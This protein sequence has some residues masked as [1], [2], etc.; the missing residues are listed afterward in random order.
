[1]TRKE[2]KQICNKYGLSITSRGVFK[3]IR[4]DHID[5][6][7]TKE[8]EKYPSETDDADWAAMWFIHEKPFHD[9]DGCDHYPEKLLVMSELLNIS[10]TFTRDEMQKMFD[11]YTF[12]GILILHQI[13]A[14]I[15][16]K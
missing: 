16:Q 15:F 9:S 14:N 7:G 4:I 3:Y 12:E 11:K 5:W 2:A 1:M 10:H 6:H 13:I 8:Y